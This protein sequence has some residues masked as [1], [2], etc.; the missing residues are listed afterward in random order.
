MTKPIVIHSQI[1]R[2][3]VKILDIPAYA[4]L[5]DDE[6]VEQH[7]WKVFRNPSLQIPETVRQDPDVILVGKSPE[8]LA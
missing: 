2:Y 4:L 8:T 1:S 6:V 3:L 5:P 7:A